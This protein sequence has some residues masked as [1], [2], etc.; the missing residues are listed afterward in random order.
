LTD[1]EGNKIDHLEALKRV[2]SECPEI[3]ASFLRYVT[4]SPSAP[5]SGF[6]TGS[7]KMLCSDERD[8]K[9]GPLL[10]R[11]GTCFSRLESPR[12]YTYAEFKPYLLNSLKQGLETNYADNVDAT[13]L[14]R[15]Y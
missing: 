3:Y 11:A 8:S 15:V 7:I 1:P 2:L 10:F 5:P 9:G 12:F 6:T 14:Q 13:G 4:N